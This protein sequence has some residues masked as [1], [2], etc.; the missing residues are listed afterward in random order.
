MTQKAWIYARFSTADQAKGHSLERQLTDCRS[1]CE[2]NEWAHDPS[3]EMLDSGKSAYSGSNRGDGSALG[4]FEAMAKG[5]Q[6]NGHILVVENIDRITRQGFTQATTF[7]QGLLENGVSVGIVRG[8]QFLDASKK[9]DLIEMIKVMLEADLGNKESSKKSERVRKAWN[10][11]VEAAQNGNKLAMTKQLPAW[12][13]MDK[14]TKEI[15]LVAH[16]VKVLREIYEMYLAGNG[17]PSI[18]QTLNGRKE[19]SWGFDNKAGKNGWTGGYMHKILTSRAV[20]GE[21]KTNGQLSIT[22]PDYY[23]QAIDADT[24]NRVA[25]LRKTRQKL[26]GKG[27]KERNNLFAGVARCGECGAAMYYMSKRKAGA[28]VRHKRPNGYIE[29]VNRETKAILKCEDARRGFGCTNKRGFNYPK[30]ERD[31]LHYY[32][33][34]ALADRIFDNQNPSQKLAEAV[35]EQARKIDV[36]QT[37]L[38]NLADNLAM[39]KSKILAERLSKMETEIETMQAELQRMEQDL[40][41]AT[42][43]QPLDVI[44]KIAAVRHQLT[45]EDHA[46]RLA[47]RSL[48]HSGFASLISWFGFFA[49]GVAVLSPKG[50]IATAFSTEAGL[51]DDEAGER[52]QD[53][54]QAYANRLNA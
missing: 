13:E 20:L 34:T 54:L 38:E 18:I 6:R 1:Y 3:R 9:P 23:P 2:R 24:F 32:L 41:Q 19:P 27:V 51:S 50:A 14:N 48:A 5:G 40:A 29:Y 43:S 10:A 17:L 8:D 49:N 16:R 35:A 53:A 28:I 31:V 46:E 33:E 36:A 37:N 15:K 52:V 30:L 44:A 42:H 22:V 26:A 12:L 21:L 4:Q 47:A 25:A 45:S 39:S 11:K 7:V